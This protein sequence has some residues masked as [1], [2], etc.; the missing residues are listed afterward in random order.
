ML[1]VLAAHL[2]VALA[3]AAI[4]GR[5]GRRV[6][7]VGAIA[8]L[9][10]VAWCVANAG[11]LLD[12]GV[13]S[14]EL[15]WV[16]ALALTVG[17]RADAFALLLLSLIGGVGVL[18]FGYASRYFGERSD[19]GRFAALLVGFAGAMVGIVTAD[20]LLALA[21]FWELTS[22]TSYLLI[23]F[24]DRDASARSAALQA[25]LV[26]GAGGLAMLGGF[27]I[28][29]EAAGTYS[30]SAILADPPG[31]TAVSVALVLVL[32]GAFTKSAQAPFH[33]WLSGAMAAPTP[34]SA[35]LHSA[36][37]VKAGVYLVARFAPAFAPL[38]GF[39]R[40]L[41]IGVG[42][43]TMLIGGYR[44]LRQH[45]LKLLLAHGTV[46]QLGFIMALVGAGTPELTFAGAA[47]LLAHGVFKASLFLVVGVVDH[48]A[49][50]RDLRALTGLGRRLPA[51]CA[52]AVVGVASMAGLPPLLGFVA[53]EAAL[54]GYLH[55]GVGSIGG[56]AL[57]G[58]VAGSALTAAYGARFL[59]GAFA[60]KSPHPDHEQVGPTVPRPAASFVA[61]AAVLAV[62]SVV[63]G[64][65]AGVTDGLVSP[66]AVA[67]DVGAA[68]EHLLLWHGLT[69]ALGLSLL[70][71]A[72]GCVLYAGRALIE[73][74]QD[75]VPRIPSSAGG[76]A[77]TVNSLNR[78]AGRTT[79]IVQN[80][81]LPVY[82]GVI[83]LTAV[84]V[85]GY[86]LVTD[87]RLGEGYTFAE[88][89]LQVAVAAIVVAGAVGTA[90]AHRRFAAVL[91]L[92]SVGYGVAVLFVLQG[93]PDLAL[94][95]LLIETLALVLFVLVLRHLPDRFEVVRYRPRTALRVGV[96]ALVGIFMTAMVLV[97]AGARTAPP[98]SDQYLERALPDG[99]G[100]NVVNVILVDFRGFDTM[101]EITVL[102]VAALGIASLVAAGRR[103]GGDAADDGEV[104]ADEKP[105]DHGERVAAPGVDREVRA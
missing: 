55:G 56:V 67:L 51:L 49:H 11:H 61:P 81:S 91:L 80:G 82:V 93:A 79:G 9:T 94:T 74:A 95:Q 103:G 20:N 47:V 88:S 76:Y 23:G 101:G 70:A 60:T 63:L 92:G 7:L 66:A 104:L 78:L 27:I 99:G 84:L 86:S 53:K 10:T 22:V 105:D 25:I 29:G 58:V 97:S 6:L 98:V 34:V 14:E 3:C 5:M 57:A 40:P 62:L 71:V 45:D 2:A 44:A 69:T 68:D 42:V 46:S 77:A 59:W 72:V 39:W 4:G 54:E 102:A 24:D 31:G 35:Y 73:R 100:R 37:M 64:L 28:L 19:L 32:L 83:L 89:P 15:R 30:L 16:D 8:P 38:V 75:R 17:L 65:A 43:T 90:I 96:A 18:V 12:G 48:Q 26:T 52:V 87:T 1:I 33:A 50:T 21:T 36:T 85:P 41:V 13:R